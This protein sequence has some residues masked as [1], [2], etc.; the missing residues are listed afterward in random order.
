MDYIKQWTFYVCITVVISVIMSFV[1]PNSSLGRFYKIIISVF[2]FI[3]FLYPFTNMNFN[4][5]KLPKF[6]NVEYTNSYNQYST[7]IDNRIKALLEKN[8]IS[9]ADV[10][11]DLTVNEDNQ[12]EI[13][14]IQVAVGDE[15]DI[16]QVKS[17]IYEEL[18]L[19]VSVIHIGG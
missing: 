8:Q 12:I 13:K 19:N 5:I 4:D 15:Y 16:E 6:D 14:S 10:D 11:C 18:Q 2:I 17:L 3:S 1:T 9:G 7:M